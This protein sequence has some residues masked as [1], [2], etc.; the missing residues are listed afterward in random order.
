MIFS[1]HLPCPVAHMVACV[2][3]N[4]AL[5]LHFAF[6]SCS[7]SPFFNQHELIVDYWEL[8]GAAPPGGLD[9]LINAESAPDVLLD[10]GHAQL[11]TKTKVNIHDASFQSLIVNCSLGSPCHIAIPQLVVDRLKNC[12]LRLYPCAF[13]YVRATS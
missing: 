5:S 4:I 10:M 1:S 13:T 9:Q 11:R 7:L 3:K 6:P 2:K 12:A 8:I